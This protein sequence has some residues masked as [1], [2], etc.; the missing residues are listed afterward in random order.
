[1]LPEEEEELAREVRGLRLG[2]RCEPTDREEFSST[3]ANSSGVEYAL[4]LSE[5]FVGDFDLG[6]RTKSSNNCKVSLSILSSAST[7]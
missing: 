1:M 4:E 6:E 3:D 7:L 5:S 2:F